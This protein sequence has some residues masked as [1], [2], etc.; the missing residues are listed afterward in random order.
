MQPVNRKPTHYNAKGLH[1]VALSRKFLAAPLCLDLAALVRSL[2]TDY[3]QQHDQQGGHRA[4]G[5]NQ[6]FQ[7]LMPDTVSRPAAASGEG[8]TA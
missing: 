4:A 3:R 2:H 1:G 5:T 8:S 6:D 7:V